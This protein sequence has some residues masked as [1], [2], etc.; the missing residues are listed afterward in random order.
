MSGKIKFDY[1]VLPRILATKFKLDYFT[2]YTGPLKKVFFFHIENIVLS[3][4][5]VFN[6]KKTQNFFLSLV[7]F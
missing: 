2:K 7:R 6:A 3:V 5:Y 1:T 4:Y